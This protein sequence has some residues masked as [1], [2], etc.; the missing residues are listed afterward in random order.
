MI[1]NK[2]NASNPIYGIDGTATIKDIFFDDTTD[3]VDN[4]RWRTILMSALGA[5][6][7]GYFA[8]DITNIKSPKHLF[9]I[10]NDTFNNRQNLG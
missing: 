4:P 9:A 1:T 6:G 10:E 5:G 2:D 7:H 8:I 3:N